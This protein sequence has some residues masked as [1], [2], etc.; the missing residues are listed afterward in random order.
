[1]FLKTP[2]RSSKSCDCVSFVVVRYL[3]S[4]FLVYTPHCHLILSKQKCCISCQLVFKRESKTY[5]C[6]LATKHMFGINVGLAQSWYTITITIYTQNQ[7]K[8]NTCIFDI[9]QTWTCQSKFCFHQ[10]IIVFYIFYQNIILCIDLT[11]NN[12]SHEWFVFLYR[13]LLA[14]W[15]DNIFPTSIN[16]SICILHIK[17]TKIKYLKNANYSRGGGSGKLEGRCP[18]YVWRNSTY[19]LVILS[20]TSWVMK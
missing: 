19:N 15:V 2:P 3:P 7:W 20:M 18:S 13:P 1:M 8:R 12:V 4:I 6:F 11:L 9:I 10:T 16:M 17:D 5:L 14:D